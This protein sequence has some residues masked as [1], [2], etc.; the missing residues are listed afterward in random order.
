MSLKATL[1]LLVLSVASAVILFKL[2][3]SRIFPPLAIRTMS[4]NGSN[5]SLPKTRGEW[6]KALNE[7][8]S[9]PDNIPA[10]SF[11]HGSPMLAFPES[12]AR[13]NPV[14]ES[15]GPK[16]PLATFLKDFGP[17]LL[18]KYE[19]KG[20]VVFSAHWETAG[21]RVVTDYGD[22][23]PLLYDYY[24]FQPE[25]YELKFDSR[26]DH[27]LAQ[28]VVQLYKEAGH[29]A[30]TTSKLETRGED[31]RGFSGP[32]LDHGVFVP[33]RL[34]FGEEFR[35]VPVVQVS[36]DASLTAEKNWSIGK[37]VQALR[38]EGILI[39]SGG[40]TV[41]NLR[42]FAAFSEKTAGR[43]VKEFDRA[44]LDAVTVPDA[45]G[46]KE[47][48]IK[49]PQHPGFRAAH[50]RAEHFVP[51]YVAAGA[52]GEGNARVLVAL[53]GAPAFAFGL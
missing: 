28:R 32:G 47:A 23:N 38:R 49:L 35:N 46:R 1:F 45:S 43:Q 18:K 13:G 42:D 53:H 6:L 51:L 9:T 39:L 25:L 22:S 21:E 12:D 4:T 29:L 27:A 41:H 11:G 16:G 50:P 10:F 26:G 15:M 20:I 34:M 31:G 40:L 19:P 3:L 36:I 33:F 2:P 24:G 44:I 37:A 48:M 14:T 8:P 7:L 30:R 17:A 5:S 52:G